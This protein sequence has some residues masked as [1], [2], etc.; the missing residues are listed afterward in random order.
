MEGVLP[1][2]HDDGP[3]KIGIT[4]TAAGQQVLDFVEATFNGILHEIR[5]PSG[6]GKPVIT[7]HRIT[8]VR[9]YFDEDDFMRLKWHI[10]SRDVK[11]HFPGK[12][13]DEAW[14]FGKCRTFHRFGLM[15]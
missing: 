12:N 13:K 3:H 8:A 11:Y 1:R 15:F 5:R 2:Q 4:I 14:R 7:L 10:E 6:D 9:P